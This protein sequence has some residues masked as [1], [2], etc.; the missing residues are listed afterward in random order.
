MSAYLL[1][2]G[3]WDV[4]GAGIERRPTCAHH[5][6][7]T[8]APRPTAAPNAARRRPPMPGGP[9]RRT[10]FSSSTGHLA[11]DG[12]VRATSPQS[13]QQ[14]AFESS[15]RTES[16]PCCRI[17]NTPPPDLH[18]RRRRHR[19]TPPAT[20][21]ESSATR[22]PN[23]STHPA[24]PA[25]HS[26]P[27]AKRQLQN[28]TKIRSRRTTHESSDHTNFTSPARQPPPAQTPARSP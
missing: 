9:A 22:H 10:A 27:P 12:R 6:A 21:H 2:L 18:R 1:P 25:V 4:G 17:G 11:R 26:F 24:T 23:S 8:S 20:V 16:I 7:T 14:S 15:E 19:H 5:A 3:F 28:A 13:E